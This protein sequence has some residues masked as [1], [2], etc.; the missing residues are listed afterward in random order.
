VLTAD[1]ERFTRNG[2]FSLDAGGQLVNASGLPVL[3]DAGPVVIDG[4]EVVIDETGGIYVDQ[5]WVGTLEIRNF[6]STGD[7]IQEGAGLYGPRP[8]AGLKEAEPT[9]RVCQRCLEDSNVTGFDEMVR[10]TFLLREYEASQRVLQ[11]QNN[12]LG[13]TVNELVLK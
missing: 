7:L 4:A 12:T 2:N 5:Q 10:M 13:R 11:M 8:G 1:G 9:A 6:A 3:T